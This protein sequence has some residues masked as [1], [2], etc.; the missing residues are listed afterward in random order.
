[1]GVRYDR[2]D[3]DLH[4]RSMVPKR[5]V[6]DARRSLRRLCNRNV[7]DIEDAIT[8]M[9]HTNMIEKKYNYGGS[10][11]MDCFKG[12]NLRRTEIACAVW[13]CQALAAGL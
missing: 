13:S 11:Y 3:H 1:M 7:L 5:R 4:A 6:A 2:P 10:S 12:A 8:V 9:E